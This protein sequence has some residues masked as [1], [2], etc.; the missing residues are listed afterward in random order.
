MTPENIVPFAK[1]F[2]AFIA[3]S[4][5][6]IRPM[7]K[8]QTESLIMCTMLERNAAAEVEASKAVNDPDSAPLYCMIDRRLAVMV[9]NLYQNIPLSV[10]LYA[11]LMCERPG[12]AI[13]WA[14]TLARMAKNLTKPFKLADLFRNCE[15][16]G[17]GVP[18]MSAVKRVWDSQ[19]VQGHKFPE[20]DNVV[21]YEAAWH[22]AFA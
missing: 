21:D 11:A 16:L 1:T 5:S 17:E 15:A 4:P 6:D 13:L 10:K 19:K 18:I 20:S 3:L 14:W 12:T 8:A 7:T 2:D 22:A 9:P